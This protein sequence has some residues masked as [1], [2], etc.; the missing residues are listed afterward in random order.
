MV[1]RMK[2]VLVWQKKRQ[3]DAPA[4]G[5]VAATGCQGVCLV[6]RWNTKHEVVVV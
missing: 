1:A 3:R 4:A 2:R 5:W 6:D